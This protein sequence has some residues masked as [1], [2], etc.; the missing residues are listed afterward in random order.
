MTTTRGETRVD[1]ATIYEQLHARLFPACLVQIIQKRLKIL[2]HF[3]GPSKLRVCAEFSA[4][5][6]STLRRL[7]PP[8][9][10]CCLRPLFNKVDLRAFAASPQDPVQSNI[11]GVVLSSWRQ[12]VDI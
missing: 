12:A 3:L 4:S 1:Q 7:V 11:I 5:S 10:L 6:L 2:I 9:V 8:C